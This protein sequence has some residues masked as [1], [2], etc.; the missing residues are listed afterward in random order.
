MLIRSEPQSIA[1]ATPSASDR[2][3]S[4]G[5]RALRDCSPPASIRARA[6]IRALTFVADLDEAAIAR[7]RRESLALRLRHRGPR[8]GRAPLRRRRRGRGADR[9]RS[10]T[11]RRHHVAGRSTTAAIA[12]TESAC[13]RPAPMPRHASR[14]AAGPQPGCAPRSRSVRARPSPVSCPSPFPP[15]RFRFMFE[16]YW[17]VAVSGIEQPADATVRRSSSPTTPARSRPTPS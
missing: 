4:A 5:A 3:S 6:I 10:P 2:R 1:S 17:R 16:Q 7:V 15:F 8:D 14:R 11:S 13:P 9:R 12:A